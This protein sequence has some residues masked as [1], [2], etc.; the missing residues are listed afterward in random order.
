MPLREFAISR[1]HCFRSEARVRIAPLT[2]IYGQ[3][4]AGKST[5]LR[6]LALFASSVGGPPGGALDL[7]KEAARGASFEELRTRLDAR[8][9]VGFSASWAGEDNDVER[10]RFRFRE[11]EGGRGHVLR[12]LLVES[13]S[14][15]QVNL[16]ISVET[17]GHYELV[18]EGEVAWSGPIG[19]AGVCPDQ[20]PT[21]PEG[22]QA[23][24][25]ALAARLVALQQALVWLTAVRAA[26]PRRRE[27]P[28]R[29]T[30]R[31]AAGAWLQ[32]HL[33]REALGSQRDLV[34]RVSEDLERMFSCAL[35]VDLD[36]GDALLRA[37]PTGVQWRLPLADAGEGVTQILPVLA[38][39]AMAERG[40]LGPSPIL[41]IEQPEMHLHADAE[42]ELGKVLAR[43]A[44]SAPAPQLVLETHSEILLNALLL[45]IAEG[46]LSPDHIA[47][48]WVSRE[49]PAG[50]SRVQS[51]EVN[52]KGIPHGLPAQAFE[53]RSEL[54]RALFQARR[55]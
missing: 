14:G 46:R 22:V 49:S 53:Q 8:N 16:R 47:L 27:I 32:D 20:D 42:R 26:V 21:V 28:N 36:K 23:S 6:A 31:D 54:A 52:E 43:V 7:S 18:R 44:K 15:E 50:E 38:L 40:E 33:A 55:R 29:A 3:N 35:H 17:P 1:V 37:T 19:F 41:C 2:L 34:T 5:L 11:E 30:P 45:E 48:H 51:I 24:L 4:N 9:E 39:L 12:D 13:R 25:N 10:A